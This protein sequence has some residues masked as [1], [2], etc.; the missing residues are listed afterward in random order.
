MKRQTETA[1][2][3]EIKG[4]L[5]DSGDTL[6]RPV[7]GQ[8]F[9]SP[10]FHSILETHGIDGLDWS[11]LG[12]AARAGGAYL[13][14]NHNLSTEDEER[15][16]FQAF[17]EIALRE[18]GLAEPSREL[19]R[20]LALAV[21]D[22]TNMEPF[23][24]AHASLERLSARGL[25]MGILSDTWPSLERKYREMGLRDYFGPFVISAL[26]GVS[27]PDERMYR[28]AIDAMGLPPENLLFVDNLPE[29]V[30][31]AEAHGMQGVV[32]ARGGVESLT[33]GDIADPLNSAP[34]DTD[35]L[36]WVTNLAELEE[37]LL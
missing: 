34:A 20:E 19:T 33:T 3:A 9:P 36:L 15:D 12:Q 7:D 10:M 35:G 27:K 28:E 6:V 4:I 26:L 21:V 5:F 22:G 31:A 24:D 37:V 17:H 16:Q 18:L 2:A 14:A 13:Q 25:R 32:M 11:K 29:N 1:M 8:W 30:R 23:P